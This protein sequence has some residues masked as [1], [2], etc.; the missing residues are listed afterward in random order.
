[1]NKTC[2]IMY[3]GEF[4]T[5]EIGK[6]SKGSYTA[7]Y[8]FTIYSAALNHYHGLNIHNGY[9]KRLVYHVHHISANDEHNVVARY[10]S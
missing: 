7:K 2:E 5:V 1:M 6:G 3:V 9:K 10:I 4:W 8:S